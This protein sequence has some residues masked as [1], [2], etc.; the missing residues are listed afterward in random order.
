[1]ALGRGPAL[2]RTAEIWTDTHTHTPLHTLDWF[3]ERSKKLSSLGSLVESE[4]S[5]KPVSS[6]QAETHL[7]KENRIRGTCKPPPSRYTTAL[8]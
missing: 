6:L 1:M 8:N 5:F 7:G 2:W 3:P 4:M